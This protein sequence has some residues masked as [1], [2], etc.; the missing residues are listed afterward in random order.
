MTNLDEFLASLSLDECQKLAVLL[1]TYIGARIMDERRQHIIEMVNRQNHF[2]SLRYH[3]EIPGLYRM[4]I[5][6]YVT[7]EKKDPYPENADKSLRY[8]IGDIIKDELNEWIKYLKY[9]DDSDDNSDLT[10]L[11]PRKYNTFKN[12]IGEVTGTIYYRLLP[13]PAEGSRFR[14][15]Y[16]D[17]TVEQCWVNNQMV[18]SILFKS[19]DSTMFENFC[20]R[21]FPLKL[22]EFMQPVVVPMND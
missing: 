21:V 20:R 2:V 6:C 9:E 14:R 11:V 5:P 12:G 1:P 10:L 19:L 16:S 13:P 18:G 15:I 3:E 17:G 4:Q 8:N 7:I 22:W